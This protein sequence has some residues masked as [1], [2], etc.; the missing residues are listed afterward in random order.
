MPQKPNSLIEFQKRFPTEEACQSHIFHLCWPE[1]RQC[2]RCGYTQDSLERMLEIKGYRP[3]WIGGDK[4]RKPM[5][6]QDG[7]YRPAGL[8]GVDDTI[9]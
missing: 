3:A 5:G 9:T 7:Y 6:E 8:I 4:I 1:E 2:P